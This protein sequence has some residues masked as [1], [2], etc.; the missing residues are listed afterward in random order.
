MGKHGYAHVKEQSS[1]YGVESLDLLNQLLQRPI[2]TQTIEI[3]WIV[4]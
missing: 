1:L 4:Q 2:K 3:A